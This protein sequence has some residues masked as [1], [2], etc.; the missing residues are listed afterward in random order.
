MS[1]VHRCAV[2]P[3]RSTENNRGV[4]IFT[5]CRPGCGKVKFSQVS[6]HHSVKVLGGGAYLWSH[7]LSGGVGISGYRSLRAAS[8]GG[9]YVKG[10][11]YSFPPGHGAWQTGL[12]SH[13]HTDI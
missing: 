5:A 6:V 8:K 10:G 11:G 13:P 4:V 12:G 3:S 2:L 7:V 1:L 9:G